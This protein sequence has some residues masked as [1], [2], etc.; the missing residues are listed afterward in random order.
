MYDIDLNMK[1]DI[2]KKFAEFLFDNSD[3]HSYYMM[4]GSG[5]LS[6]RIY[7]YKINKLLKKT[8]KYLVDYCVTHNY[9]GD[10]SADC[11]FACV[12]ENNDYFR[13]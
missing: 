3:T 10:V 7:A 4:C 2:F 13:V 5:D 6:D 8:K 11:K 9:F 12:Y 1:P